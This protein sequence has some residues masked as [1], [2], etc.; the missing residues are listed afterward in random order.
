MNMVN[1]EEFESHAKVEIGVLGDSKFVSF[2]RRLKA[3]NR[4]PEQ[5]HDIKLSALSDEEAIQI[6]EASRRQ[7]SR[8]V[9]ICFLTVDEN[10]I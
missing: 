2:L 6:I 4:L 8:G 5:Y 10:N 7:W 3:A 9:H 1:K